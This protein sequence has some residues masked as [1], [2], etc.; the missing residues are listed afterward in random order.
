M[1][2]YLLLFLI[3]LGVNLLPAFG[4]PTWSVLVVFRLNTDMPTW[5]LVL[6]GAGAAAIGR[7]LLANAF[8]LLRQRLSDKTRR[9]LEAARE[10]LQRRRRNTIIALGLFAMSPI[11]SAQL[12]E[13]AGLAGVRLFGFTA[14]FFAGRLISYSIYAYTAERIRETSF[15]EALRGGFSNPWIIGL[16]LVLIAGLVAMARINWTKLLNR[17]SEERS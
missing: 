13:A 14:A 17:P 5:L 10:A 11:P 3:V 7:Y 9:N 15:G 12:F 1:H 6:L 4:P 2:D 16:Q 8:W